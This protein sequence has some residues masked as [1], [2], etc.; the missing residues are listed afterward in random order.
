MP[1]HDSQETI[2][3]DDDRLEEAIDS[4]EAAQDAWRVGASA[5]PPDRKEWLARYAEVAPALHAYFANQDG[6][7]HALAAGSLGATDN[8]KPPKIPGLDI[9]ERIGRGGMGEVYKA[10]QPATDRLVAFKTVRPEYLTKQGLALFIREARLLAKCDH[11]NIVQILEFHPEHEVPYFLMKY[12]DGI[13]LDKALRARPWKERALLFK[14]VVA[15]V[16][17]A[18]EYGV[19]HGDLKPANIFVWDGRSDR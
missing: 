10:Y 4:Y 17:S 7:K 2:A 8:D 15:G 1:E 6:L 18:H 14:E 13:P 19:V 3:Y 5:S 9:R 16:S 12:I 11:P